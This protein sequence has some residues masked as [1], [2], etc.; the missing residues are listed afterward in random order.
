MHSQDTRSEDGSEKTSRGRLAQ[1]S[2]GARQQTVGK[3]CMNVAPCEW[4]HK[5]PRLATTERKNEHANL[6]YQMH[7]SAHNIS[8]YTKSH[9]NFHLSTAIYHNHI[10]NVSILIRPSGYTYTRP[11]IQRLQPADVFNNLSTNPIRSIFNQ[12]CLS[13]WWVKHRWKMHACSSSK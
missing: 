13:W 9:L 12:Q 3:H 5:L 1:V 4:R 6:E 2:L 7:L 8:W 11:A 10:Y